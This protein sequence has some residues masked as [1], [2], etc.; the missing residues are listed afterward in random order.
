MQYTLVVVDMQ[1][2]FSASLVCKSQVKK[3]VNKA[4]KSN[5]PIIFLEYKDSFGYYKYKS[6]YKDL[7][8]AGY[9]KVIKSKKTEDSGAKNVVIHLNKR[10]LP[11]KLKV[12]GVL[13]R[14]CVFETVSNL[15]R[16][17]KLDVAVIE[18]ACGCEYKNS[19]KEAIASM[20]SLGARI[21]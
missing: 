15:I 14:Y 18:K 20:K 16:Y 12:C 1:P 2:D 11:K 8:P 17:N 21:L 13:T 9:D 6:T 5:N 19:H 4:V 7:V 10:K 3:E